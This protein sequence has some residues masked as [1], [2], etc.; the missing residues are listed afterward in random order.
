MHGA[1]PIQS[2]ERIS[3]I[4]WMSSSAVLKKLCPMCDR[5]PRLMPS[6]GGSGDGYD[7]LRRCK[8]CSKYCNFYRGHEKVYS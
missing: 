3:L 4:I 7:A 8:T 1:L 6:F 2:G 5:V